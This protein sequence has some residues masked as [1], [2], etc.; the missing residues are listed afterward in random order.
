MDKSY[1]TKDYI[2]QIYFLI[3]RLPQNFIKL[4]TLASV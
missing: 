1:S 4:R 3:E 2:Q